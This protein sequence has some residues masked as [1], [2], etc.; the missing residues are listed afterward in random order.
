METDDKT[1][2]MTEQERQEV[3]ADIKQGL[4]EVK[5]FKEGKIALQTARDFLQELR[6]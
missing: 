4:I 6:K 2:V 1:N 5:L 3:L